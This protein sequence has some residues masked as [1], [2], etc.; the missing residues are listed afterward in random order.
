M[1][2]TIIA[3]V[4]QKG[5][6]GKTTITMQLAGALSKRG[7]KVLVVDADPQGTAT[8]WASSASDE[9]PFPAAVVGLSAA[10]DKV[11]RE[12]VK[13][14]DDYEVI[15]IDCPPAVDSPAP[16]SA[17]LIA[18]IAIVPIIP[19]PPDLWA[20][21][22][23]RKLIET[24]SVVNEGLRATLVINDL[25]PRTTLAK[26]V[27]EILPDFGVPLA[28]AVIHHRTAYRQSAAFGGT[29]HDLGSRAALAIEEVE[30]LTDEIL[31]MVQDTIRV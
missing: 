21:V 31:S 3:V 30:L 29:V 4:N 24:I 18:D 11:H 5:G 16:H 20:A 9:S 19:S 8:R 26:E 13:F 25:E 1:A 6:A 22:G 17:L 12:V 10:G 23:I 27:L 15:I 14:K 2:V 28:T 7:K